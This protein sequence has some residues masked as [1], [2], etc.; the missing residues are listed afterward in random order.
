VVDAGG[1]ADG[2]Y[3]GELA[4]ID[5]TRRAL[6]GLVID[7]PIRDG[8]AV[9]ALGFPVFHVGFEPES[10]VKERALSVGEPV[11][12][13]GVEIV[14]GDQV[15]A[16]SD[17]VLV[18]AQADWLEVEAAAREIEDREEELRRQLRAGRRLADL[19]ALSPGET[20]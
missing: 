16:D 11:R 20:G 1:R 3:F 14:P 5:A 9:A 18:V 12:I 15:V 7:G 10:C 19:L 13:G 17:G 4:V 2:G 8:H 6:H